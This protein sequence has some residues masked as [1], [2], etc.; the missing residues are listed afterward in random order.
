MF[1]GEPDR[2]KSI[3]ASG[4]LSAALHL[5]IIAMLFLF[6]ALQPDLIERIIPVHLLQEEPERAP[7]PARRVLAE[8]RSLDFAP[9]VQAVQP[10]I[11]NPRVVAAATPAIR[12]EKLQMDALRASAAPTQVK[13]S[14]INVD[15]VSAVTAVSGLQA[16]KV[17]VD[18][19]VGPAVR[20]PV[21][22]VGPVGPSAGPRKVAGTRGDTIGTG[23]L[24]ISGGS[25]VRDGLV[26][27]RD[28]L[29]APTGSVLVSVDTAVGDSD[30]SGPGGSGTGGLL[31]GVENGC[32]TR[33]D[34]Q[35]YMKQVEARVYE[36]WDLAAGISNS[37]VQLRFKIDVAGSASNVEL[38]RGD[39]ALGADAVDAMRAA[40]PFR[41]MLDTVRCLADK[42]LLLTFTLSSVEG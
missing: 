1:F 28:V 5:G 31:G 40:S 39:N 9:A 21:R 27:A 10:Q 2:G 26:T 42:N 29:G 18:S 32:T 20:G 15:R 24:T 34:V 35:A 25:S 12:A 37:E 4:S 6:A 7:A 36:R 19:N 8:R 13:R 41:P 30:F 33:S 23:S 3:L 16:S 14:E 17:A 11:V 22:A 38:A